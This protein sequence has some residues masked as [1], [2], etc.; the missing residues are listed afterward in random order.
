M[1]LTES[2][3]RYPSDAN[4]MLANSNLRGL[5]HL[6]QP[7]TLCRAFGPN[8]PQVLQRCGRKPTLGLWFAQLN[9]DSSFVGRRLRVQYS[10]AV[11]VVLAIRS[12]LRKRLVELP[13]KRKTAKQG[14]VWRAL[15]E[16]LICRHLLLLGK[17][18]Q[19]FIA[20]HFGPRV[21]GTGCEWQLGGTCS[22]ATALR[23]V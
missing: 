6:A 9:A 21:S 19:T 20:L 11:P 23:L 12:E 22:I 18:S 2:Q 10:E 16:Y 8:S 14:C 1:Q 15:Y 4:D 7:T 3:E 13:R 5:C 17:Q